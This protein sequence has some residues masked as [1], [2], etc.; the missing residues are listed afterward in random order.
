MNTRQHDL[1]ILEEGRDRRGYESK[2]AKKALERVYQQSKDPEIE[3]LRRLLVDAQK[4]Q[5]LR[6]A[7]QIAWEIKRHERV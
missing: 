2:H 1:N 7:E 6:L 3:R 5:D 4:K